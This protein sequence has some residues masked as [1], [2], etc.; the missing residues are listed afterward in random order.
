LGGQ[1]CSPGELVTGFNADATRLV[2]VS[3]DDLDQDGFTVAE[4]DCDDRNPSVYP[5]SGS[6]F[7][8][9]VLDGLDN[10]CNGRTDEGFISAG[11]LIITEIMY[12]SSQTP[13]ENFEWFEVFNQTDLPINMRQW[14]IRDQSGSQQEI[15]VVLGD[16]IV[17]PGMFTVLCSNGAAAFNGG[18]NCDYE[19]GVFQLSNLDDEVILE[20]FASDQAEA[21]VVVD[22]VS[23][24]E[25]AGWSAATSGSLNLDPLAFSQDNNDPRN[26]CNSP[27]GG[28]E[29]P[30]GDEATPG[31]PNVPCA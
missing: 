16:V 19:Y 22:E 10:N 17:E 2:C 24:D 12:D 9:E 11:D 27:N 30:N 7:P 3:I 20:F 25:N 14:L 8:V 31:A 28:P 5:D 4:G 29:L 21:G 1:S 13:D 15:A 6:G 18:V 26:W 23:Y